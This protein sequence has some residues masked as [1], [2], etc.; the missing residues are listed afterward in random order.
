MGWIDEN[1]NVRDGFK[2]TEQGASTSVWAAVG[3]E[4][5]GVGGLYLEDWPRPRRG[6]GASLERRHAPRPGPR[7]GRPPVGPV[8]EDHGRGA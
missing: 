2:T 3:D 5:E 1:G 7:G 8:G 4:L 6:P